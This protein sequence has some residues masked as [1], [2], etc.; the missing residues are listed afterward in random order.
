VDGFIDL[1]LGSKRATNMIHCIDLLLAYET[2][3]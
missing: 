1:L 2:M 3:H